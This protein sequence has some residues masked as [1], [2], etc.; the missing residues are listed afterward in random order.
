MNKLHRAP[1]PRSPY[2]LHAGKASWSGHERLVAAALGD[3]CASNIVEAI[4]D[5]LHYYSTDPS[6]AFGYSFDKEIGLQNIETAAN[7]VTHDSNS[8]VDLAILDE[9]IPIARPDVLP[10]LKSVWVQDGAATSESARF[11]PFGA[12]F[13]GTT[14]QQLLKA[15]KAD[16][17][18]HAY[19]IVAHST[20]RGMT[21][22]RRL[23]RF[24][25]HG[26]AVLGELV[27]GAGS[28]HPIIAVNLPPEIV[29][30]TSGSTLPYYALL[31]LLYAMAI[32]RRSADSQSEQRSVV[33]T[34]SYGIL[35]GPKDGS[36]LFEEALDLICDPNSDFG[37]VGPVHCVLPM[38]NGRQSRA[39]AQLSREQ[40]RDGLAVRLPPADSTP[41]FVEIYSE[42]TL[43]KTVVLQRR[44]DEQIILQVPS[45]QNAE[46]ETGGF[47]LRQV[48]KGVLLAIP[49]TFTTA[50]WRGTDGKH[51]RPVTVKPGDLLIRFPEATDSLNLCIQRDDSLDGLRSG[52]RQARFLDDSYETHDTSG[53]PLETDT[54]FRSLITRSGTINALACGEHVWRS[55]GTYLRHSQAA[56]PYSG[57]DWAGSSR[58]LYGDA[59]GPCD[60]SPFLSGRSVDSVAGGAPA[61]M[62]GTSLAAPYLARKIAN[63]ISANGIHSSRSDIAA[64]LR[65]ET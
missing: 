23:Q 15:W 14:V 39:I 8:P 65:A 42:R 36:S 45:D 1:L 26:A 40:A 12:D 18:D 7:K 46:V 50:V 32:S 33:A 57:M 16:P 61:L 5:S 38:G 63:Y 10:R 22:R 27:R 53:R 49:P 58:N 13:P 20:A 60:Q 47:S 28:Q 54:N 48:N 51:Q 37:N 34:L 59:M 9:G 3:G 19:N 30:D 35:A 55:G 52:G 25:T 11:L 2:L 43:P 17:L 62:S 6:V 64:H 24:S 41:T 21:T 29:R 4:R 31:G 56:V 44:G